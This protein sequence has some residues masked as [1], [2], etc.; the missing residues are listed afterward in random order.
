MNFLRSIRWA[1][2]L[3]II[4]TQVAI[5]VILELFRKEQNRAVT[6]SLRKNY[7]KGVFKNVS[8]PVRSKPDRC[9]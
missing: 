6:N 4:L 3:E 2:M 7:K 5:A 8:K 9:N 1:L